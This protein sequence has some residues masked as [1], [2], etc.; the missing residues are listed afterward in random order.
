[1]RQITNEAKV[2]G[3]KLVKFNKKIH[4]KN[5]WMTK[6]NLNSINSINKMDRSSKLLQNDSNLDRYSII[7]K[8]NYKTYNNIIF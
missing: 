5:P 3:N 8:I 6:G 1:M 4:N 7:L 2:Y